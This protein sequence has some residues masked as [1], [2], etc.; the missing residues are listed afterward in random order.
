MTII[1]TVAILC[2]AIGMY[3]ASQ[4]GKKIDEN[5]DEILEEQRVYCE[6]CDETLPEEHICYSCCGD[7]MT[8][9]D[10]KICPTC[11]EHQ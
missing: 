4:I 2:I 5:I 6:H 8:G 7:D 11:K 9:K 3:I 10:I 1:L